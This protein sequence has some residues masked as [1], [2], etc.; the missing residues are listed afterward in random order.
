MD[1]VAVR[2]LGYEQRHEE[3]VTESEE[4]DSTE[5]GDGNNMAVSESERERKC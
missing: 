3:F 1:F 2:T 5:G 4:E